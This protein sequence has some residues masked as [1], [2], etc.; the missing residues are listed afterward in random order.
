[1]NINQKL[2][3]R[4]SITAPDPDSPPQVQTMVG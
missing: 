1:M 3:I 2:L 4:L